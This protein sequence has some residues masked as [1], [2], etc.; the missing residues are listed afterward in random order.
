M[1]LAEVGRY[2]LLPCY[3]ILH[4]GDDSTGGTAGSWIKETA[5]DAL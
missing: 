4:E 3:E 5:G 2:S 1:T